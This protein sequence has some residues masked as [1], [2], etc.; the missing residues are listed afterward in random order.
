MRKLVIA[1]VVFILLAVGGWFLYDSKTKAVQQKTPEISKNVSP[2]DGKNPKY[3]GITIKDVIT[4]DLV[5]GNGEAFV[6]KDST[7][8]MKYQSWVYR[9]DRPGNKGRSIAT[10]LDKPMRVKL[11]SGTLVPGWETGLIGMLKGGKRQLII[12]AHL[13]YGE[14]GVKN[15]VPEN[16]IVLVEAEVVEIK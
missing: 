7:I 3:P 2:S 14:K 1:S 8:D 6:T 15:E 12:P 16:A 4:K 10:A 13:A 11:G 5:F 9:P